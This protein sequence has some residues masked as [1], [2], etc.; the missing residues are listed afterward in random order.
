MSPT[1]FGI[2]GYL[3]GRSR[4]IQHSN[5]GTRRKY[6]PAGDNSLLREVEGNLILAR[7]MMLIDILERHGNF[8]TLENPKSSYVWLMP[9]LKRKLLS[10]NC[11]TTE[12]DQCRYG[13]KLLDDSGK[14]VP[15]RSPRVLQAIFLQSGI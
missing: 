7:T 5:Q 3:V 13:L 1:R 9:S 14:R 8:W 2:L 11:W 4:I 15:V 6:N 10:E 12:F